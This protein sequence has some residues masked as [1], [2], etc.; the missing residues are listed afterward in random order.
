M[1]KIVSVTPLP[2]ERDSRTYKFACSFARLGHESIVVEGMPSAGLDR[3]GVPFELRS[4]GEPA[5]GPPPAEP[6]AGA[7]RGGLGR[8]AE[9]PLALAANLRWNWRTLR[10]LP[11]ADLY[12]LHSYNQY[13]AVR[14]RARAAGSPYIYDAHDAYWEVADEIDAAHDSRLTR[15]MFER[16]ERHCAAGA[17]AISTVSE[18]VAALLARRFGGGPV[19]VRNFQDPRLDRPA[20]VGVREA[21]GLG[22]GEFLLVMA[23]N[24]KPGDAVTEAVEALVELPDTVHLA[25]VGR[26]HRRFAESADRRGVGGRVHILDPVPPDQVTDFIKGADASP[27]LYRAWTENFEHAL[28]NRF[29]HAVAAGLPLLYPPLTEIRALCERHGLGIPID[30]TDPGSIAA[31]ARK[32]AGDRGAQDRYRK[33]VRAAL[34]ELSWQAEEPR[35]AELIAAGLEREER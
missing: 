6:A 27:I 33:A 23:G 13:R 30:P 32:L 21:T 22:S 10:R 28:P 8:L 5:D 18:G 34:P 20:P 11:D 2:V 19:V 14:R 9:P 16:L 7:R 29:S 3:G 12:H 25:L 4:V 31:G 1:A 26:G 35:I 17:A 15:S 24:S